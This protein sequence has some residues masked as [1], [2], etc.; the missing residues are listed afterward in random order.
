M[1]TVECGRLRPGVP[2]V[3]ARG[4]LDRVTGGELRRAVDRCLEA[5]SWAVVVDLTEVTELRVGAVAKL[6]RMAEHVRT[7]CIGLH[8][9]T[10]GGVVDGL[11]AGGPFGDR[12]VIHHSIAA[13]QGA[14]GR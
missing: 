2:V 11:L 6:A 10:K 13:V 12:L 14:L 8:I 4:R 1:F 7:D 5:S 9:V 3:R